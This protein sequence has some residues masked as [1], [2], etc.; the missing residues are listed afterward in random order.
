M[1]TCTFYGLLMLGLVLVCDWTGRMQCTSSKEIWLNVLCLYF[2]IYITDGGVETWVLRNAEHHLIER[3]S[4]E[5]VFQ[6]HT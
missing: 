3:R 2:F 5:K 1:M 6:R 4:D